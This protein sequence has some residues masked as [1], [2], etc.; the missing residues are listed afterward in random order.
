MFLAVHAKSRGLPMKG[1]GEILRIVEQAYLS[2]DM[3]R[4]ARCVQVC[5]CA[6]V[7]VCFLQY[8]KVFGR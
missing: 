4:L 5:A 6:R 3:Q 1:V 2:V 7:G 8:F